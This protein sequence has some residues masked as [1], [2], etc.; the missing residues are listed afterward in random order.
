MSLQD[1]GGWGPLTVRA[2]ELFL[3]RG[4]QCREKGERP[5]GKGAGEVQ[6]LFVSIESQGPGTT[7]SNVS[8]VLSLMEW[9]QGRERSGSKGSWQE[10]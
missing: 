1:D 3:A 5:G 8:H 6:F 7:G 9:G 10:R 4:A 2:R